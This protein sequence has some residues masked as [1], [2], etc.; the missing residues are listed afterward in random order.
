M[1]RIFQE[2]NLYPEPSQTSKKERVLPVAC[3]KDMALV[4]FHDQWILLGHAPLTGS[5]K[6]V[7]LPPGAKA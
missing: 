3:T 4:R 2:L 6:K 1:I 5:Q 7:P